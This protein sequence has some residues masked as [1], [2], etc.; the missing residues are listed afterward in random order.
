[1]R[2]IRNRARATV[3][4]M[5]LALGATACG[6]GGAGDPPTST[7]SAGVTTSAAA[8]AIG[9]L[10]RMATDDDV[11]DAKATFYDDAHTTLHAIAAAADAK[12]VGSDAE[13]LIAMQRVEAELE[14]GSLPPAYGDDIRALRLIA[15]RTLRGIGFEAPP[16]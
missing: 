5:A 13:L 11:T 2:T 8:I 9:A 10:C 7:P 4:A 3:L 1:V 14:E 15:A 16:C 6:N 12:E